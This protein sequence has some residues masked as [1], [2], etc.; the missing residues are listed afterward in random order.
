MCLRV[1]KKKK[2]EKIFFY[3]EAT[4]ERSRIQIHLS[5]V[6]IR[7]SGSTPKCHESPTLPHFSAATGLSCGEM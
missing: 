6:R 2:Y 3:L 5:E 1:S 7:G 4:E